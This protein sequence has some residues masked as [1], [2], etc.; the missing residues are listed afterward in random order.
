MGRIA[1]LD[2]TGKSGT[3]YTFEIFRYDD[4]KPKSPVVYIV[5]NRYKKSEGGHSHTIIYIGKAKNMYD[6]FQ[7]HEKESCFKKEK[8]NCFGYFID[9]SEDSRTKK[10]RDL[11]D[12]RGSLPPCNEI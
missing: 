4:E 2:L 9:S 1:T 12:G 5:S 10:E 6:R 11:I 8:A 3:K 7:D